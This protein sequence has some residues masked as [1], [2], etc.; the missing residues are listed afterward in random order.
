MKRKWPTKITLERWRAICA[1]HGF[2]ECN[3]YSVAGHVFL[4]A[5]GHSSYAEPWEKPP[6]WIGRVAAGPH[7]DD[8][9]GL[10]PLYFEDWYFDK[11]V[12]RPV[13]REVREENMRIQA[14]DWLFPGE[15]AG[16]A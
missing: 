16:V 6:K 10:P 13:T 11:G 9:T 8:L 14:L 15:V 12:M 3:R 4:T 7:E 2:R 5:E 1:E